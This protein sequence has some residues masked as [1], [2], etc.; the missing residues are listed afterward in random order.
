MIRF[1]PLRNAVKYA[2]GFLFLFFVSISSTFCQESMRASLYISDA[3]GLTLAD[4]NFT[5]YDDNYCNCVDWDDAWKM[6]NPGENFAVVRDGTSLIVERRKIV[7]LRDT[8]TFKIWN[9][10]QGRNYQIAILTQYLDHPGLIGYLK[11]NYLGTSVP[12]NLNGSSSINFILD[13]N[14]A[15]G[16]PNRFQ[17]FYEMIQ[18]PLP[19]QFTRVLSYRNHQSVTI[20]WSIENEINID[21]YIIEKSIDGNNFT[22]LTESLSDLFKKGQYRAIDLQPNS[23]ESF[24][25]VKAIGIDGKIQFSELTKLSCQTLDLKSGVNIYPNPVSNKTM[26]IQLTNLRAGNYTLQ[27]INNAGIVTNVK[28]LG[29]SGSNVRISIQLPA[30]LTPGLYQLLMTGAGN[31]RI[32][33]N[34]NIL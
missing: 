21:K 12:V 1:L 10:Q 14:P 24:Y 8:T 31:I 13:A 26:N 34:V 25:R 28:S 17:L 5:N 3:N 11:D 4:G 9:L 30:D 23:T 29:T 6:N 7:C 20:E 27:L 19:V 18:S 33:T 16:D 32:T 22:K 2:V 15:S